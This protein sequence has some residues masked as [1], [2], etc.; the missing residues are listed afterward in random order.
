MIVYTAQ[1]KFKIQLQA[2]TIME[3]HIHLIIKVQSR[4]QFANAMRYMAGMIA[5]KIAKG[6]LWSQRVWSRI[7][8]KG[9]D[10][11]NTLKYICRNPIIPKIWDIEDSF[12]IYL[13]RLRV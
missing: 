3:N 6:K 2:I 9:R 7:V 13:G 4:N 5:L 1:E 12:N 10:F 11:E 8:T